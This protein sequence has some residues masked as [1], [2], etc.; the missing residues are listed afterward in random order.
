VARVFTRTMK[1]KHE[2]RIKQ[3]AATLRDRSR[4]A[5]VCRGRPGADCGPRPKPRLTG[6]GCQTRCI[7]GAA[8]RR[9]RALLRVTGWLTNRTCS[10]F[11]PLC[12][13]ERVR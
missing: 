8:W 9:P 3:P 11:V 10:C 5:A 12:L 7:V 13:C 1:T 4:H 2:Q 6:G